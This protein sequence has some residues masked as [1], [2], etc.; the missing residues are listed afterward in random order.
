MH[1]QSFDREA[2]QKEYH[3][4]Q[5][6][7]MLLSG[8]VVY[9]IYFLAVYIL[10]EFGCLSEFRRVGIFGWSAVALGVLFLTL[11]A[12]L[13]TLGMAILSFIRWRGFRLGSEQDRGYPRFMTFVGTW[14][15]GLFTVVILMT[16]VPMFFGG[17]C[18]WI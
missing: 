6:W 13:I 11:V 7:F 1:P 12:A 5:L 14:L 15:N 3:G 9:I 17:F 4:K 8:P 10:G 16:S 2:Q 18:R